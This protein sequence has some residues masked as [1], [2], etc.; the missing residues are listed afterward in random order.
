MGLF[1]LFKKKED[2]P[3]EVDPYDINNYLQEELIHK[4]RLQGHSVIIDDGSLLV[5][6]KIEI[7]TTVIDDLNINS[8]IMHLHTV[9]I[10]EDYFPKGIQEDLTVAGETDKDRI[11]SAINRFLSGSLYPVFDALSNKHNSK[12]DFSETRNEEEILWRPQLGDY[13]LQGEWDEHPEKEYL[14]MLLKDWL[15]RQLL[16][17]K[18]NWV[19]IHL[20]KNI[21]GRI[22]GDCSLNNE[23]KADGFDI[24]KKYAQSWDNEKFRGIKQFILLQRNDAGDIKE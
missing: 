1:D 22:T 15:K 3:V 14:L 12:L 21:A 16:D 6:S 8:H 23:F 5:D 4:L 11:D 10:V 18:Y 17:R 9:I 20:T 19:K 7:L 2:L 13:S 24:L